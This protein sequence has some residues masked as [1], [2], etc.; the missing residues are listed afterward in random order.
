MTF[1]NIDVHELLPQQPPFVFIDRLL[2][3]DM[4]TTVTEFQVRADNLFFDDGRLAESALVENIAQ[5][6]AARLG[7]I[8][9]YILHRPV[10]VG[11]IGSIRSLEIARTARLGEVLTTRIDVLE[12]VMGITLASCRIC[13]GPEQEEIVRGTLKIAIEKHGFE[14]EQGI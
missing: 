2:H 9:K 8:N 5:T 13:A 4:A 6:C 11:F 14:S 7:Y 12:D 10:V 3:F 1:S